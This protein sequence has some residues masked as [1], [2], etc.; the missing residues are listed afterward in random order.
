MNLKNLQEND[1]KIKNLIS[2]IKEYSP[3]ETILLSEA[4]SP[5][6]QVFFQRKNF[7]K[8]FRHLG[9]YLPE[10]NLYYIFNDLNTKKYYH[11]RDRKFNLIYKEKIPLNSQ[12]KNVLLITDNYNYDIYKFQTLISA[13]NEIMFFKDISLK[14]NF[15]YLNYIFEKQLD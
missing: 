13:E 3:L 1:E 6:T 9:Y 7:I 5:Y 8:S 12:I 2:A 15:E 11:C 10:Y 4:D 14:N